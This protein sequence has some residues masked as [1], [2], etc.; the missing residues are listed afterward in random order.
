MANN[1]QVTRNSIF[2][3]ATF[4]MPVR[5]I[6]SPVK[7]PRL[8]QITGTTVLS[9][10]SGA[11]FASIVDVDGGDKLIRGDRL[12]KT[13]GSLRILVCQDVQRC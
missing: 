2:V 11:I 8:L 9:F 12:L 13:H 4:C 6:L 5:V 10:A 1:L 3:A 7:W